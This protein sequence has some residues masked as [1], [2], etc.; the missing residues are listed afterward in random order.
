[1]DISRKLVKFI[2]SNP[3]KYE[4]SLQGFG[5]LR[6]YISKEVRLHVWDSRFAVP[7]VSLIHDHPWDFDSYILAG[8]INNRIFEVSDSGNETQRP[9]LRRTIKCGPGGGVC[10]QEPQRVYLSI[11]SNQYYNVGQSYRQKSY[12]VHATYPMDGTVTLVERYFK[13]DTEHAFVFHAA[14]EQW[15]SAEPRPATDSE[16]QDICCNSLLKF[17]GV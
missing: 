6:T 16:I 2:L 14:D 9:Y 3:L 12:E 8:R 5:M 10:D 7:N 1:L 4:W 11:S 17:V 15:V 13:P